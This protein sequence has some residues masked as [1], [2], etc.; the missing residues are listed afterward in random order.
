VGLQV[1][2]DDGRDGDVAGR[3]HDDARRLH[4]AEHAARGGRS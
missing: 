2:G 4:H 1:G 3:L